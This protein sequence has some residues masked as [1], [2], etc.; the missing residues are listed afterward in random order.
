MFVFLKKNNQNV[1]CARKKINFVTTNLKINIYEKNYFT[2]FITNWSY[3][4]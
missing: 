4:K 1:F 2:F 3:W